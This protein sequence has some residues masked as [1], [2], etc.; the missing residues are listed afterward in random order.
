MTGTDSAKVTPLRPKRP[1]PECGEPS[2]RATFPFCS[3]R[4]KDID[5][6]RWF[7]GSYVISR[8]VEDEGDDTPPSA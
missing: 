6:N 8:P 1:C 7:S 4:C 3:A 5:L 2:A